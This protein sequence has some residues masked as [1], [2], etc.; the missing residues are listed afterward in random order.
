MRLYEFEGKE[1]VKKYGIAV[2]PSTLARS[3]EDVHNPADLGKSVVKA[4]LLTVNSRAQAGAVKICGSFGEIRDAAARLFQNPVNGEQ[5]HSVLLEKKIDIK[6]EYYISITYDTGARAAVIL[7][8]GSGGTGIESSSGTKRLYVNSLD[9]L[10]DW[11]VR[12]M[13]KGAGARQDVIVKLSE[14]IKRAYSCFYHEDC[15]LLEINPLAETPEGELI[16]LDVLA[17]LDDDASFRHRDRGLEGRLSGQLSSREKAVR[18][19]NAADYKGTIKY[20]E[21]DGEIGFLAA[22]GGG[23]L[24][25]MDALIKCGCRPANYTEYSGNP[26]SDKVCE[27]ARQIISKPG[28]RGL[29]IVGAIANFTRVD[30]TMEGIARALAEIRPRFPIVVRRSGPYEKEGL[31]ILEKTARENGLDVRVFGKELPMTESAKIIAEAAKS[32]GTENR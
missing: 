12:D 5:A 28:L 24:A 4:Q 22:G 19:A 11:V 17:E 3:P 16:A 9:G 30:T 2:P 26:S 31:G 29:W 6:N 32:F 7:F 21:L 15:W 10:H 8:N 18:E 27:L 1:T 14:M 25:C 23:S 20:I 13:L